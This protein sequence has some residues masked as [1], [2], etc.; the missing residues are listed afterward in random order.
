M[1]FLAAADA[2][3]MPAAMQAEC[4]QTLE[5]VDAVET[6]AR[7]SILRAFTTGQGYNAD[8]DYSARAWLIHK[9]RITRGA[10]AIHMK[11]AARAAAHPV[12]AAALAEPVVSESWARVICGLTDQ[13]PAESR[14]EADA[15]LIAA[16]QGGLVLADLLA[17]GQKMYEESRSGTPDGDGE[18][19]GR[20]F[21]DR[22]VRLLTTIYGAGLLTG[23]LTPECAAVVSKVLDAL[24]APAG[25]E[26][27]RT[28]E[29]RYHDALA[30]AMRRLVAAG[31]VPDRAGQPA[32]V[33]AHVSLLDLVD[34]DADSAL[35]TEWTA[36][37]RAQ[38][39]AAR[40]AASETGGDGGVWL[41]GDAAEGFACDAAITP[42]VT[43]EV[44]LAA[45][46][47]LVR[48]CVELAGHGPG[49]CGAGTGNGAS[50]GRSPD[51]T[52][53]TQDGTGA[54]EPRD[55]RRGAGPVPPT[56]RGRDALEKA[57]IGKAVELLSGPGGLASFLR[58]GL[59]GAKLGG[60]SLPLDVGMSE[61]V[62]AGI[63]NAVLIRDQHCRWPGGCGQPAS[64]CH[65]HHVRHKARG[66]KTSVTG[67]VLLC[68][69]HHLIAIHRW[70]WTLA[71]NGDGTTT[72]WNPDRTKT[73][74]SHGPPARTG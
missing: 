28:Q 34:L 64:T 12:V 23:D 38:W 25:A 58:R 1:G 17:L 40:A 45:L 14:D 4:L 31:L 56:E 22:S 74:H 51:G 72:A 54:G 32:R 50:S 65:I 60:P 70:G 44:H 47:D 19:P 46:E 16:V 2:T 59:L 5:E 11:W 62:P 9:T 3:A 20:A 27:T 7:A 48:L 43:G 39:A 49:R 18:D 73:L 10:A 29:Q 21:E 26:D 42:V 24:S 15:I 41:E 35:M 52:G 37:V 63:R 13:L 8:A 57:I 71:L 69:F 61:N 53:V 66:G 68:P 6:A 30:E 55:G 36:R 67:C 33:L